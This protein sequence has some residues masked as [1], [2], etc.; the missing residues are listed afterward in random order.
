MGGEVSEVLQNP[1]AKYEVRFYLDEFLDYAN[2][3]TNDGRHTGYYMIG[4]VLYRKDNTEAGKVVRDMLLTLDGHDTGA[5]FVRGPVP[6]VLAGI[7]C[8]DENSESRMIVSQPGFKLPAEL[9]RMLGA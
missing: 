5:R 9:E 8:A 1:G 3:I 7:V 2:L 4:D 6:D